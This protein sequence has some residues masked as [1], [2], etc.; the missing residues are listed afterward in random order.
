MA[1][2]MW[3]DGSRVGLLEGYDSI[4]WLTYSRDSGEFQI[5][6]SDPAVA[7]LVQKGSTILNTDTM[8]LGS[9]EYLKPKVDSSG[10]QTV[11]GNPRSNIC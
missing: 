4:Q 9:V 1:F 8:E 5:T 6:I 11:E 2:E 10:C 3:K 7:V